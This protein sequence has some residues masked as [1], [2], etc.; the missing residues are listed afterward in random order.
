MKSPAERNREIYE[1]MQKDVEEDSED[2]VLYR[3][4][5]HIR[6]LFHPVGWEDLSN[7]D[8]VTALEDLFGSTC[9]GVD[10]SQDYSLPPLFK[11][12]DENP[13]S[14]VKKFV[15]NRHAACTEEQP[16]H[17]IVRMKSFSDRF[18]ITDYTPEDPSVFGVVSYIV[19]STGSGE[20]GDFLY[21]CPLKVF[22][23]M[24]PTEVEI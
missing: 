12:K 18:I 10:V 20:A 15:K 1:K 13:P 9:L 24:N 17:M 8:A 11:G 16:N 14:L 21:I 6:T 23:D 4:L 3:V 19:T 22:R 2:Q 5:K 7:L